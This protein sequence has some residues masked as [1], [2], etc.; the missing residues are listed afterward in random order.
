MASVQG[1][2]GGTLDIK[3]RKQIVEA[4]ED[5]AME[6]EILHDGEVGILGI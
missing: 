2:V 1:C 4:L 5:Q 6:D 3:G